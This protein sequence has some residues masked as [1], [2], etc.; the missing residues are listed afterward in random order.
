VCC[1]VLQCVAAHGSLRPCV[2][3]SLWVLQCVAVCCGALQGPCVMVF[4]WGGYD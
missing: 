3:V 4:L 2:L 1:G